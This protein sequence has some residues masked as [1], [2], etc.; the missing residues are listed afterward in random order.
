MNYSCKY[1]TCQPEFL[2][3]MHLA[4]KESH[5]QLM[6]GKNDPILLNTLFGFFVSGS[7]L[8]GTCVPAKDIQCTFIFYWSRFL[9]IEIR[10]MATFSSIMHFFHVIFCFFFSIGP[11]FKMNLTK[12][13]HEHARTF[14]FHS[15]FDGR[16]QRL[17]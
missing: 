16:N 3:Y 12:T 9:P 1:H 8:T 11:N 10:K 6:H 17:N 13:C 4:N 7:V 14:H 2:R 5:F 15:R